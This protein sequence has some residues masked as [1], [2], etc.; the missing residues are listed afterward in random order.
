VIRSPLVRI[1]GHRP[2]PERKQAWRIERRC[3][4]GS[5]HRRGRQAVA[6]SQRLS[7]DK[8]TTVPHAETRQLARHGETTQQAAATARMTSHGSFALVLL[9]PVSFALT[10]LTIV[11]LQ[12]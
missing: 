1:R 7:P 5:L 12:R 8:E 6:Q 10:L 9:M 4:A 3:L 2:Q 11:M